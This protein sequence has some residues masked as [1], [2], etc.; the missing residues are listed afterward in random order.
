MSPCRSELL[1]VRMLSAG[2]IRWCLW[3]LLVLLALVSHVPSRAQGQ[4]KYF[5]FSPHPTLSLFFCPPS[6]LLFPPSCF[7]V[8][9]PP[10]SLLDHFPLPSLK[11]LFFLSL[12]LCLLPR[13]P[14]SS[15]FDVQAHSNQIT[16]LL[17]ITSPPN[18]HT[19]SP[20]A[21]RQRFATPLAALPHFRCACCDSALQAVMICNTQCSS[22]L[23][24]QP[25]L[26]RPELFQ[27]R[28]IKLWFSELRCFR[29]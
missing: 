12:S 29:S 19:V 7:Q 3:A 16:P 20:V 2:K 23:C 28:L 13:F 15:L 18:H 17:V 10:I 26:S 24:N 4:G 8:F 27:P 22:M 25:Q 21:A 14:F 1:G 11:L 9:P 6:D 5:F